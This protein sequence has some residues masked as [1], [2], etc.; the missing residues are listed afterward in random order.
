MK[1]TLTIKFE[2][3]NYKLAY[4]AFFRSGSSDFFVV[5]NNEPNLL[6]FAPAEFE[7]TYSP[8]QYPNWKFKPSFGNRFDDLRVA[9]IVAL[10][11]RFPDKYIPE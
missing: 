5:F 10:M 2:G 1:E 8:D 3:K 6:K 11:D 7:L 9:I 4:T